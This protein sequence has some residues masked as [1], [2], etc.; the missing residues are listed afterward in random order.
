MN[1]T[2]RLTGPAWQDLRD[3]VFERDGH[4]CVICH[5][6]EATDAD[7]IIPLS[8]GGTNDLDNLQAACGFCNYS[9]SMRL[10]LPA[11][12]W[13]RLQ[14]AR[15]ARLARVQREVRKL[16]E[17]D[18]LIGRLW[19]WMLDSPETTVGEALAQ[20]QRFHRRDLAAGL[21]VN[22]DDLSTEDPTEPPDVFLPPDILVEALEPREPKR[23]P[24]LAVAVKSI[25][26]ERGVTQQRLAFAAGISPG[27]V[28]LVE[29]G[30]SQSRTTTLAAI[31]T[32]LRVPLAELLDADDDTGSIP[33]VKA[34]ANGGQEHAEVTA[35]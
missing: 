21:G 5:E 22:E 18:D 26:D 33:V 35:K 3:A 1:V 7:H 27:A 23:Y 30:R 17:I 24:S 13:S 28:S 15:S 29:R 31:A 10:D 34:N 12:N 14:V 20:E 4:T 32:A 19:P 16:R 11:S 2:P 8:L 6:R 25:R 9:K